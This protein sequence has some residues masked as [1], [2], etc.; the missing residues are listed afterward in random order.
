[1]Q[2]ILNKYITGIKESLAISYYDVDDMIPVVKQKNMT[3][4]C[5]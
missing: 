4:T 3:D 5:N 1:M 2:T